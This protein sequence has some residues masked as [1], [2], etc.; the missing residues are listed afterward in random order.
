MDADFW[1]TI[2]LP[3]DIVS[4][5]PILAVNKIGAK[6]QRAQTLIERFTEQ[7]IQQSGMWDNYY[8]ISSN[9]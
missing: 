5:R 7:N 6:K 4:Q 1:P 8:P 2:Q 3:R 9:T